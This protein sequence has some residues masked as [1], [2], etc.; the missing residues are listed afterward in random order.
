MSVIERKYVDGKDLSSF[1]SF[2]LN[3][4]V[5]FKLLIPRKLGATRVSMHLCGDGIEQAGGVGVALYSNG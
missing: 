4:K 1:S 5:E 3:N 2:S